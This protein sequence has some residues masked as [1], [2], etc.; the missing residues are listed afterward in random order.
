MSRPSLD[1]REVN[2]RRDGQ[3]RADQLAVEEP[4]EIR[5][6]GRSLAVLMRPPGYDEELTVGFLLTEG[7][8]D[9]LDDVS[10]LASC[11]DALRTNGNNVMQVKLAAGASADP[12]RFE[13]AQRDLYAG[14]G[15][16]LCGKATIDRVFQ[17]LPSRTPSEHDGRPSLPLDL[18]LA[19]TL[20]DALR[21]AQPLFDLTG[22]THAAGAFDGEGRLLLSREDVGRHN[23]VDKV[24]GA[25]LRPPYS[26]DPPLDVVLVV[27]SRAGFEVV[28]KAAIAGF[29]ALITVGAAT[30]LADELARTVGLPLLSFVRGGSANLHV[31]AP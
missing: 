22:G 4:L 27:S 12:S 11:G 8:I 25:L 16:G 2:L 24:I 26:K 1:H 10:A 21:L 6:D 19:C 20:P 15:C 13:R 14:S 17:R 29:S 23:A 3:S 28:Q 7:V 18:E 30:T 31:G 9:G 5:I